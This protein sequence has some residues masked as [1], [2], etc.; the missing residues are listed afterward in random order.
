M[1]LEKKPTVPFPPAY[2]PPKSKPYR[3]KTGDDWYSVASAHGLLARDLIHFNYGTYDP[4]E[5]NYYLRAN[6]GCVLPT[7]DKL[8]WKFSSEAT[9]GLIY[10][11][12]KADWKRPSFP[13]VPPEPVVPPV[14]VT[15]GP[16]SG[17]WFG[18]GVQGGGHFAIGGKDTVEAWMFSLESYKNRFMM[19]IDGYR[20]GPGLGASVGVTIVVATGGASPGKFH[21]LKVDG[22]D[23][24]ANL[25]GKWGDLAKG[26]K[27]MSTVQR[28]ASGAKIVDKMISFAEWEKC[29]DLVVNAIKT[30]M[31]DTK[32]AKPEMNVIAIPG[33]GIGAE[34][35]LYYSWGEVF[36]HNVILTGD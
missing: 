33:A 4:K 25:G 13:P 26:A 2:A 14:P 1:P 32:S 23:F 24:Q 18:I 30:G 11:P 9:P 31:I 6:V 28:F 15:K 27:G 35:S 22:Y 10:L 19:N 3:V 29:R 8:N 12:M 21:M 34:L 7:H 16:R 5:V 36:V 20:A 17:V